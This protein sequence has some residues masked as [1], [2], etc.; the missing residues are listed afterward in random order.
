MNIRELDL[1]G[2]AFRFTK[3]Y[4]WGGWLIWVLAFI[5]FGAGVFLLFSPEMDGEPTPFFLIIAGMFILA[6][7]SPGSFQ[8]ELHHIRKS[9]ISQ[10]DLEQKAQSSGFTV[11]NWFLQQTTLVPTVDPNDWILPAPGPA[12]WNQENIYVQDGDGSPLPEHP[13]KVGT[14]TPATLSTFGIFCTAGILVCLLLAHRIQTQ[15]PE[16]GM[17][18]SLVVVGIGL[19]ALLVGRFKAKRLQQMLDTHTSLVRSVAVGHAELVGQVRPRAEGGL[20]VYVDGNQN[21][22][23]HHMV[24]FFWEYEQYQCRTVQTKEGTKEECHWVTIRSDSGGVPFMLHDGTGGIKIDMLSFKRREYG[25]FLKRWDGAFAQT[26]GAQLMASAVAGV[27]GAN[28]KKHRWTLYGLRLG[29]PV[30]VLAAVKNRLQ[31]ELASE[32]LD[33]TLGHANI[34]VKGDEDGVGLKSVLMRGTELSNVGK[35]Y[36]GFEMTL[37]GLVLIL[38][39]LTLLGLA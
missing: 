16:L 37:P 25:Q 31:Q 15:D 39:G 33:G 2:G 35:S 38:G 10:E 7:S 3:P 20:T 17:M 32:G 30:Y 29:D 4:T 23:M 19:I 6:F 13:V 12:S 8:A 14:P 9:A 24:G 1:H 26:L 34:E 22:V 36:S 5:I 27:F 21:M 11:D 18:P 28:V